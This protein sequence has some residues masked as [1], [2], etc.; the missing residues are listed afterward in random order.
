MIVTS[1]KA[2]EIAVG[3]A[4]QLVECAKLSVGENLSIVRADLD[5]ACGKIGALE[6]RVAELESLLVRTSKE[7]AALRSFKP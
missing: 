5:L 7:V 1:K 2:N 6:K 4:T 3:V